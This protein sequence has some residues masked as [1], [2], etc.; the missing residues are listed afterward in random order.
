MV[1]LRFTTLSARDRQRQNPRKWN[2]RE[3]NQCAAK[4][5]TGVGGSDR[6][7]IWLNSNKTF[8]STWTCFIWVEIKR[9]HCKKIAFCCSLGHPNKD[10]LCSPLNNLWPRCW[11]GRDSDFFRYLVSSRYSILV[12]FGKTL[13]YMRFADGFLWFTEAPRQQSGQPRPQP[14]IPSMYAHRAPFWHPYTGAP[15]GS[16]YTVP[17]LG[18]QYTTALNAVAQAFIPGS[19]YF[20]CAY[21]PPCSPSAA[22]SEQADDVYSRLFCICFC[23]T[24]SVGH[25]GWSGHHPSQHRHGLVQH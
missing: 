9:I 5:K 2:Y 3:H 21:P 4:R 10:M 14:P 12:T 25:E 6:W 7:L 22:S 11:K 16:P 20:Y 24:I 18:A 15:L 1:M 8:Y 17:P 19:Q 13:A 23:L